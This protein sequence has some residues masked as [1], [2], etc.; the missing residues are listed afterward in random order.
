MNDT[1][2][3]FRVYALL[4]RYYPRAYQ[5]AFGTAQRASLEFFIFAA[6][7]WPVIPK[8]CGEEIDY[9]TAPELRAKK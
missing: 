4:L 6:K 7:K 2:M 9:I 8:V 5:A 3:A 1:C